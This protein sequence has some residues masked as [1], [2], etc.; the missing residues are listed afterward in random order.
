MGWYIFILLLICFFVI[1]SHQKTRYKNFNQVCF[2]WAC[3]LLLFFMACRAPSVGAD[4]IGYYRIYQNA[5]LIEFSGFFSNVYSKRYLEMESGYVL[6]NYLLHLVFPNPQAITVVNSM[7]IIG[8]WYIVIHRDSPNPMLSIWLYITLGV[9]QT[10]MNMARNAISILMCY[11]AVKFIQKRELGRYLLVVAV[12]MTFHLSAMFFIPLYWLPN[13]NFT[14]R[15]LFVS[16]VAVIVASTMVRVLE[17]LV[18]MIVPAKYSAYFAADREDLGFGTFIL[19]LFYFLLAAFVFI[20]S[21]EKTRIAAV[22]KN[23]IGTWTVFVS[24]GLYLLGYS[25]SFGTRGAALFSPYLCIFIPQQINSGI[26]NRKKRQLVSAFV[27]LLCAAQYIGRVCINNI[28]M[29]MP[30]K[31]FWS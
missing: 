5:D 19:G 26:K 18:Y 13:F 14:Y 17:P 16:T 28:G 24:L 25:F 27:Y 9:F 7:L 8:L 10:Q 30:Y 3:L 22:N 4:T 11:Y 12:A 29:T 6:Y 15:R 31:F 23:S 2:V 20:L 21:D 1:L